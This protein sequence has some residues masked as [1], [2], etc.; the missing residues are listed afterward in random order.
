MCVCVCV[1]VCLCKCVCMD[2]DREFRIKLAGKYFGPLVSRLG[3]KHGCKP[4]LHLGLCVSSEGEMTQ[5]EG[6]G[7]KG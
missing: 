4:L 1:C 7:G 3:P 2:G 5:M 6:G